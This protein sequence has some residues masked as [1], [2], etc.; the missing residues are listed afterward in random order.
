MR[1]PPLERLLRTLYSVGLWSVALSGIG[2]YLFARRTMNPTVASLV[3]WHIVGGL[4]LAGPLLWQA[5]RRSSHTFSLPSLPPASFITAILSRLMAVLCALTGLFLVLYAAAGNSVGRV[6]IALLLHVLSGFAVTV[7]LGWLAL[8]RR[9]GAANATRR[10]PQT[11]SALTA[12]C[13]LLGSGTAL[14][15]YTYAADG[16]YRRLTATNADQA[17]NPLFPAGTHLA[18]GD[19]AKQP[20]PESCGEAGCH[21]EIVWQ[22]EGSRHARAEESPYYQFAFGGAVQRLGTEGARWCQGCH[23]PLALDAPDRSEPKSQKPK[24][25]DCLACHAMTH[26]PEPTGNGRAVYAPPPLYPFAGSRDRVARWLHGFLL[27]VRPEPHRAALAGPSKGRS[28]SEMCVPCH[29]LSVNIPQNRYKFLRYD[30]TWSEWQ[31]GPYSGESIHT[32]VTSPKPRDCVDCHMPPTTARDIAGAIRDHAC[33]GRA[34]PQSR[35]G[36][37]RPLRVEIF[38]LRR[39]Q[40]AAQGGQERLDAPLARAPTVVSPGQTVTVDVLV[41]NVG[42]GHAFPTGV[43]D[44]REAWLHFTVSDARGRLRFQSGTADSPAPEGVDSR[45]DTTMRA[46][47]TQHVT[48]TTATTAHR[49]GLLALD[50]TGQPL[51]RGNLFDMVAP[52]FRRL[53]APGEGDLARYRFTI[54]HDTGGRLRLAVRLRYRRVGAAFAQRA[55][56][57][58]SSSSN[59]PVTLAEHKAVLTVAEE[60]GAPARLPVSARD[61]A[62]QDAPRLYAYGVALLLQRDYARARRAFQQA[63]SLAARQPEPLIA[64]GRTYLEEGDLLAARVQLQRALN[65]APG[66]P[67]AQAWLGRTYRFMGQYE[68]ALA[69]L[70]P[71]AERY[72]RDRLLWFDLGLS[73]FLNGNREAAVECFQRM[74]DIDPDDAAAHFNLIRCYRALGRVSDARRE[75][76]IFHTLRDDEPLTQIITPYLRKHPTASREAL[77]MHEHVLNEEPIRK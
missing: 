76:A 3:G 71:L 47:N 15:A 36:D 24:S 58:Q 12:L 42:I 39:A 29:R 55:A 17:G 30:D 73:H 35:A 5:S 33:L 72:P 11:S 7:W 13:L 19:W 22:W 38:A 9:R 60:R 1:I 45:Q 43:P 37:E 31:Q 54:P 50:R 23:S 63:A 4:L 52:I 69:L 51:D 68:N 74:L 53:I 77:P 64:L 56:P 34:T 27:R 18:K 62:S 14:A 75:E 2:L 16:Y 46:R 70:R 32:F 21:P 57:Q 26:V 61:D 49:Y 48:G 20:A 67:S 6:G 59:Q 41:E 25:V 65:L 10:V 66:S 40:T 44:L 8:W 28:R